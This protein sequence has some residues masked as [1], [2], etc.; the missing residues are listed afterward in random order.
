MRSVPVQHAESFGEDAGV[1][2]G[3][4][5]TDRAEVA[6]LGLG[7]MPGVGQLHGDD[8]GADGLRFGGGGRA[9]EVD[10]L[11]LTVIGKR[12]GLQQGERSIRIQQCRTLEDRQDSSRRIGPEF[13]EEVLP[14]ARQI[15][16]IDLVTRQREAREKRIGHSK[17][18]FERRGVR[19]K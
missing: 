14:L 5:P 3:Q 12:A 1:T 4:Q 19:R 15:V 8:R 11:T 2:V 9:A 17:D 13:V 16:T 7:E 10:A 18:P 6:P